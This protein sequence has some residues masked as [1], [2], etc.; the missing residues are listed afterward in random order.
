MVSAILRV[1][2]NTPWVVHFHNTE[3]KLNFTVSPKQESEN[4]DQIPSKSCDSWI[5]YQSSGKYIEVSLGDSAP[6]RISDDDHK[7]KFVDFPDGVTRQGIQSWVVGLETGQ[8]VLY[9]KTNQTKDGKTQGALSILKYDSGNMDKT[10]YILSSVLQNAVMV[11]SLV[12]MPI[13]G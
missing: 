9:F 7:W 2:N 4:N 5:P 8:Y 1:V 3:D 12:L 11:V 10:D 6:V 13:F